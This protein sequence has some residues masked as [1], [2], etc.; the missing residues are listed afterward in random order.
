M[1][2]LVESRYIFALIKRDG[3]EDDSFF[4]RGK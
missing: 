1:L 3:M 4:L 2:C